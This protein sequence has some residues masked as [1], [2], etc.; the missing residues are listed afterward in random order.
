[1]TYTLDSR[2][3]GVGY[4]IPVAV[5]SYS[6]AGSTT[7]ITGLPPREGA[8]FQFNIAANTPSWKLK[9]TPTVGEALLLVRRDIVPSSSEGQPGSTGYRMQKA[10]NEHFVLLPPNGQSNLVAG[11]YYVAVVS[12]GQNPAYNRTGSNS[13]DVTLTSFGALPIVN[14]GSVGPVELVQADS[15][16]GGEAKAYQFNVPANTLS[17]EVELVVQSGYPGGVL[18]T[19]DQLPALP[20]GYGRGGGQAAQFTVNGL[21]TVPNPTPGVHSL[22]VQARNNNGFSNATYTVR[23]R[24]VGLAPV[25]FDGGTAS[26]VN[27]TANTWRYFQVDVPAGAFG[28]DVRLINVT[29]GDPRLSAR[30]AVLPDSLGSHTD[31]GN[32]WYPGSS[33]TWPAGYQW[34]A[35]LDWTGYYYAPDGG[36]ESGRVLAMGMGNPLEP[37]TYLVGVINSGGNSNMSYTVQSRGIGTNYAVAVTSLGFSGVG[38]LTN[39]NGLAPREAAYYAVQIPASTPSWKVRMTPTAGDALLMVQK[40]ALPNVAAYANQSVTS[41]SGGTKM[42]KAGNEHFLLLPPNNQ[43]NLVAGTYYLA[44]ASEGVNPGS[45]FGRIGTNS[46]SFTLESQGGIVVDNLGAVGAQDLLRTNAVEGGEARAYQFTVPGGVPVFEARLEDRAGNPVMIL[47]ATNLLPNIYYPAY[48]GSDGGQS[49]GSVND[50]NLITVANPAP[51]VY[52]LIVQG[53]QSGG[54]PDAS[55]VLRVRQP[56][57]PELNFAGN[58][59]TNGLTNILGGVLVDRQ[60]SYF[61]VVVPATNNGAPVLAWKLN[62]AVS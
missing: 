36:N 56:V 33:R 48:Y 28:W 4:A 40:D 29:A 35:G 42:Q 1:M 23:V 55:Y 30:R 47:S 27:Q 12:E 50:P 3:I 62:L 14:L 46:S 16:E 21:T 13:C 24:A 45:I 38:S 53:G 59:N 15:L 2:G 5:L 11:T 34:A 32:F 41:F 31:T 43:S 61:K 52:S 49:A 39:L 58:L 19:N 37:G 51:G 6:G 26:V 54:Y 25:A 10:T 44:V 7:N 60:R 57:M 8:Y 17:M 22:I 18:R 20:D 9:M